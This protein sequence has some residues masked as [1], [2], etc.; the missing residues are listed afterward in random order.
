MLAF[1]LVQTP[2]DY[3]GGRTL[4]DLVK[5][6]ESRGTD[7]GVKTA[8][9]VDD[10]FFQSLEDEDLEEAEDLSTEDLPPEE[11]EGSDATKD[12]L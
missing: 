8:D 7:D 1:P 10:E 12:E 11:T 5:Y 4:E 2:L 9:D 3:A 6:V